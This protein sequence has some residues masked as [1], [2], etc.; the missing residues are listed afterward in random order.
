MVLALIS[1][2]FCPRKL[3]QMVKNSVFTCR[4]LSSSSPPVPPRSAPPPAIP[5][6][7]TDRGRATPGGGELP[8]PL[9]NLPLEGVVVLANSGPASAAAL[10]PALPPA[11]MPSPPLDPGALFVEKGIIKLDQNLIRVCKGR[12]G[13]FYEII[14]MGARVSVKGEW[15]RPEHAGKDNVHGESLILRQKLFFRNQPSIDGTIKALC[16]K[17]ISKQ[18]VY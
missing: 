9:P 15:G 12:E 2:G 13:F 1:L 16:E 7:L 17:I 8:S 4:L 5:R 14:N 18:L 3:C 6:P 11:P 10:P